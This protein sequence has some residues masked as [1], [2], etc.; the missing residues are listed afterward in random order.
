[1]Q[2][3]RE[4]A[5]HVLLGDADGAMHRVRDG[6]DLRCR[7]AGAQLR[8]RRQ[9]RL[10]QWRAPGAPDACGGGGRTGLLGQH[11]QV[12]LHR[13]KLADGLAELTSIACIEHREFQHALHCAGHGS[14]MH[15]TAQRLCGLGAANTA[16]H[17]LIG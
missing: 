1:M 4:D 5:E 15:G 6:R 11:R 12:L 14:G 17:C 10:G 9:Q 7:L 16:E 2:A 8:H 3:G 13:L